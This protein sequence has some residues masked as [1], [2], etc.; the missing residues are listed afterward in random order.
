MKK[1]IEDSTNIDHLMEGPLED[2]ILNLKQLKNMNF[3]KL[4]TAYTWDTFDRIE[5][6]RIWDNTEILIHGKR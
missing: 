6:S 5:I 3:S 1:L 4:K 2:V